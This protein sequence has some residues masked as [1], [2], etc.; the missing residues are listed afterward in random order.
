MIVT[1]RSTEENNT[2]FVQG[3]ARVGLLERKPTSANE[4]YSAC[5]NQDL[6][7][8]KARMQRNLDKIMNY[9]N[10]AVLEEINKSEALEK[11]TLV[12]GPKEDDITPTSTTMQFG[13]ATDTD[14]RNEIKSIPSEKTNSRIKSKLAIVLYALCVTVVF[15][16]IVLNTGILSSLT[17]IQ[18]EKAQELNELNQSYLNLSEEIDSI[19]NDSHV[20]EVAKTEYNMIE[21]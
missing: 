21:K 10:E 19:S 9:D 5:E 11:D 8:A 15:A 16:L 17:D 1:K 7:E 18:N 2:A 12:M 4:D 14:I 3:Q 13:D 6:S 20:L